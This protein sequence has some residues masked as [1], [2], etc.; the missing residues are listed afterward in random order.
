MWGHAMKYDQIAVGDVVSWEKPRGIVGDRLDKPRWHALRVAPGAEKS[1]IAMLRADGVFAFCPMEER[2]RFERGK[3]IVTE[4]PTVTQIVYAKFQHLP[5]WDVLKAR[6]IITGVFCYG[7]RPIDL[8]AD[9]IRAVQGLPTR[10]EEMAA[11]KAEMMA[12]MYQVERG[13][14]A[15]FEGGPLDGL[16]VDV[17]DVRNGRVWW[18]MIGTG[19]KGDCTVGRVRKQNV[20]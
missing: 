10:A 2:E 3:K 5:Q 19:M 1:R 14:V 4:H 13:D 12:Q 18:Q 11:A 16:S 7:T 20:A 17:L 6:R 15:V 9:V 8:P